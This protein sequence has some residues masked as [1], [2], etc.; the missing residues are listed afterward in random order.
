MISWT[1]AHRS[2]AAV[3]RGPFRTNRPHT[4]VGVDAAVVQE[5]DSQVVQD[6]RF[7]Q[8]TESSQVV[9]PLQ[10]VWVPQRWEV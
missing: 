3:A 8:E 7:V 4:A 1:Q 9:L 6:G 10:D 5:S 2:P